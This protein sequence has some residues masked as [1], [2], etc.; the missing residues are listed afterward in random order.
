[1]DKVL[2]RRQKM[3][4]QSQVGK[5]QNSDKAVSFSEDK[6]QLSETDCI[7][8][9]QKA[10]VLITLTNTRPADTRKKT[11]TSEKEVSNE[12]TNLYLFEK[13]NHRTCTNEARSEEHSSSGW[14]QK[15]AT[16]TPRSGF[17]STIIECPATRLAVCSLVASSSTSCPAAFTHLLPMKYFLFLYQFIVL[18]NWSPV[19][20]ASV[21]HSFNLSL[22]FILLKSKYDVHILYFNHSA[23]VCL[24]M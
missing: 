24:Q 17:K 20:P 5:L 21:L 16:M 4:R 9:R 8:N 3:K 1:M 22:K 12:R 19:L 6:R 23:T 14:E 18:Q 15:E 13:T 7:S 10:T 2:T 11:V